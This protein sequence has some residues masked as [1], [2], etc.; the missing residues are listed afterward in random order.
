MRPHGLPIIFSMYSWRSAKSH[1]STP[2]YADTITF[3]CFVIS[4][5]LRSKELFRK[6]PGICLTGEP[7]I[8]AAI[9]KALDTLQLFHIKP[10]LCFRGNP[11]PSKETVKSIRDISNISIL[12]VSKS[13]NDLFH[14]VC[15]FDFIFALVPLFMPAVKRASISSKR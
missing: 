8:H 14:S 5:R 2:V 10:S 12:K 1:I 7:D 3:S 15:Q 6:L 9:L 11:R 13:A 4:I